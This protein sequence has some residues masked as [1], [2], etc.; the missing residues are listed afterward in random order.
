MNRFVS[1][2]ADEFDFGPGGDGQ[3]VA[4]G[5]DASGHEHAADGKF[6]SGGSKATKAPPSKHLHDQGNAMLALGLTVPVPCE[7]D[8]QAHP[9]TPADKLK[10]NAGWVKEFRLKGEKLFSLLDIQDEELARKLHPALLRYLE[11]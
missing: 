4:E 9:M 6:G 8:F 7:H 3:P 5:K 10:S 1:D 11:S 2:S